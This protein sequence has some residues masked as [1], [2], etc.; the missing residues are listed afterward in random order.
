MEICI[1]LLFIIKYPNY[2][3]IIVKY[4]PYLFFCYHWV[5]KK[6]ISKNLLSCDIS[7]QRMRK[8]WGFMSLSSI[9]VISGWWKGEYE[10]L[11]AM[12]C[13]L[14]LEIIL[15]PAGFEPETQ[16]SEVGH[17]IRLAMQ[18][19]LSSDTQMSTVAICQQL[20][21]DSRYSLLITCGPHGHVLCG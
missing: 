12:K 15:P 17:A 11:S 4:P 19:L 20:S 18:M 5:S 8:S 7:F 14:G 2:R 16:R 21:S 13:P 6:R 9:S 1:K 3:L 10:G